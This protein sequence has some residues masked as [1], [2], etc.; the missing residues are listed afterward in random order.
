MM[1][2]NFQCLI[3]LA[4]IGK[5]NLSDNIVVLKKPRSAVSES[6]RGLRTSLQF[7]FEKQGKEQ[8]NR[9]ILVT[10]SVSGEGKT[11]TAINLASVFSLS[12]K[13]TL[14]LGLDL[15]K[16]KIFDD[17]DLHNEVGAVDYLA[18]E[19]NVT[20]IIQ[21]TGYKNL[22]VITSGSIPPNPSEILMGEKIN[23]LIAELK[24]RYDYIVMDTP[25]IGLVADA[26]NLMK[27]ADASL[28]MIRQ[29]YTKKGMLGIINEKYEKG[30]VENISFVLNY[31]RQKAKYGY[32][33][34]N[35]YGYGYGKY[36]QAYLEQDKKSNFLRKIFKSKL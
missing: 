13:K 6:F 36:G 17:F 30:E 7:S 3:Y 10:S 1:S 14:I 29:D 12:N 35:D 26:L 33:Y 4:V 18:G 32:S 9:C 28:Y 20:D 5:S 22:D 23:Q 25:P 34:G 16:P 15:R 31:F 11:F 8:T 2:L 21:K 24:E 27:F 19:S